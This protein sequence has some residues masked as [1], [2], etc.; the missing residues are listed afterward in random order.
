MRQT[1]LIAAEPGVAAAE[2][3]ADAL[4]DGLYHRRRAAECAI[5]CTAGT[6][7][8]S[9]PIRIAHHAPLQPAFLNTADV[10]EDGTESLH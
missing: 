7:V 4:L 1:D 2:K 5:R 10:Y 9:F 6:D 3:V 8:A